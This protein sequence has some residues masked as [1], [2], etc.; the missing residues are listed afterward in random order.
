MA[1][2]NSRTRPHNGWWRAPNA[3]RRFPHKP[4]PLSSDAL[5]VDEKQPA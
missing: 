5:A 2:L 4:A 3:P 1:N